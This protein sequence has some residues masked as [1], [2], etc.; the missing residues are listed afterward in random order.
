MKK[1]LVFLLIIFLFG[2]SQ[3]E[4]YYEFD[5]YQGIEGVYMKFLDQAPPKEV[6]GNQE[7]PIGLKLKN[8]GAYDVRN[9]I[10]SLSYENDYMT[11]P[12]EDSYNFILDGKSRYNPNGEETTKMYY[13][14]AKG[15][16]E[17][18]R[19]HDLRVIATACYTYG[20]HLSSEICIDP[21][22]YNTRDIEKPCTVEDKRFNGQG[23][24]VAITKIEQTMTKNREKRKPIIPVFHITVQNKGQ[25]RVIDK[26]ST[27]KY[28]DSG[29][30]HSEDFGNVDISASVGDKKMSC[31]PGTIDLDETGKADVR[32][33]PSEGFEEG[34]SSYISMI[35]VDLEYGYTLSISKEFE[36]K[37]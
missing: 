9:G 6:Y 27:K 1:I 5:P 10:I 32:C 23:A 12:T 26:L 24:P 37:R 3:G 30:L 33:R 31:N 22:V 4:D 7:F 17:M 29:N 20:T 34:E 18:S 15:L 25:G 13:S 36:L 8:E 2:C 16:D 28:C 19:T 14:T 21:D 35:Q 11:K